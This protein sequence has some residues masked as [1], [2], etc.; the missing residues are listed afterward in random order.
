MFAVRDLEANE[1]LV[2]ISK[3]AILEPNTCS[4]KELLKKSLLPFQ[5][6]FL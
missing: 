6:N 2:E 1:T 5:F 4:I 3:K